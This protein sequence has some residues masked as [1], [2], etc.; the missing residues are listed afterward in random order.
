MDGTR[1]PDRGLIEELVLD[2][3]RQVIEDREETG[4]APFATSTVLFGRDGVLDS[5]GL[6]T[7]VIDVEGLLSA[8]YGQD[9]TIADDRAMSQKNSPFRTVGALAEYIELL[10]KDGP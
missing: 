4:A 1:A 7:L 3:L 8:K 10:V 9:V 5:L 2:V 6:V